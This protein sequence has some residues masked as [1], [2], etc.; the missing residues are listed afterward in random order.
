M[1]RDEYNLLLLNSYAIYFTKALNC[2]K[3]RGALRR[4]AGALTSTVH[5]P[6]FV[7]WKKLS[8]DAISVTSESSAF[9]PARYVLP[10]ETEW[11]LPSG[12]ARNSF[13]ELDCTIG[14]FMPEGVGVNIGVG[15]FEAGEGMLSGAMEYTRMRASDG[16]RHAA[17]GRRSISNAAWLSA[18]GPVV[19]EPASASGIS[20]ALVSSSR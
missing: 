4:R 1:T 2:E 19:R 7:G 5:A 3:V 10:R 17:F 14:V 16:I 13:S 12:A 20:A 11:P 6:E 8:T 9:E 18:C 15:A